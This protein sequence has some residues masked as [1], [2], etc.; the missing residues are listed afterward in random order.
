MTELRENPNPSGATPSAAAGAPDPLHNLYRMSRTAGL[1]SGD[2]VAINNTAVLAFL[3]GLAGVLA[4]LSPI[5]LVVPVAAVLC[6]VLAFLQVRRSNGTQSGLAFAAVAVLLGL[7]FGGVALGKMT[8]ANIEKR[9]QERQIGQVVKRLHD[10]VLA[11]QYGQAYEALFSEQFKQEFPEDVFITRWE[12]VT[13]GAGAI[14]SISWGE[15]AEFELVAGTNTRRGH[16]TMIFKF[17]QAADV[18]RLSAAFV[19]Q[20][21]E[22]VIERI[23]GLFDPAQERQTPNDPRIQ[24]PQ[25]PSSPMDFAPR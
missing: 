13:R 12:N 24:G 4:L 9:D 11:E 5:L 7:G 15:R 10:L 22:W 8:L 3:L 23:S 18:S 19:R 1:G 2:Y 17:E 14:E 20:G 21:D 25:A 16:A 6:G